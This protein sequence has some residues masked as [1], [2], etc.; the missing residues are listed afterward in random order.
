MKR[1]QTLVTALAD[2]YYLT[3]AGIAATDEWWAQ[4]T[5]DDE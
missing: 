5:E 2:R 1:G 4:Q 3:P